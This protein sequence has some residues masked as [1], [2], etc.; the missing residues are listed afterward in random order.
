M[1]PSHERLRPCHGNFHGSNTFV[2]AGALSAVPLKSARGFCRMVCR[3][4]GGQNRPKA[5][6]RH[7]TLIFSPFRQFIGF[8]GLPIGCF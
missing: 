2:G 6:F 1:K 3:Q 7:K 5:R 8:A 4:T